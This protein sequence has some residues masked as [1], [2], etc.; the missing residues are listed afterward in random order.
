MVRLPL[1]SIES[2]L[3]YFAD[4]SD[5]CYDDEDSRGA[6]N[7]GWLGADVPFP[8]AAAAEGLL[9]ALVAFSTVRVAPFRGMHQCEHCSEQTPHVRVDGKYITL[10][11]AEIRVFG[12]SDVYA[13]PNLIHH[14]VAVHAY[15]PPAAF[16]EAALTGP[17][18]PSEAYFARLREHGVR[19]KHATPQD[20]LPTPRYGPKR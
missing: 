7:V 5:Y 8:K 2:G 10:A 13:A 12:P 6:K 9:E 20:A 1:P 14:Y 17:R 15:L 19:W 16:V 4:L 3:V 11:W 18:P